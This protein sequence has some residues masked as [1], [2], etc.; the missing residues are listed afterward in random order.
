FRYF[1]SSGVAFVIDMSLLYAITEW[2]GVHYLVSNI[3][4]S[5]TAMVSN[6]LLSV[7]WVFSKRRVGNRAAEF[8]IF[9]LT[10]VA[11]LGLNQLL[12]WLFTD[13]VGLYYMISKFIAAVIGYLSKFF[14]RRSLLF[15]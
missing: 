6:Y 12:L 14:V 15:G 2:L 3:I 7:W 13:V 8:S 9:M 1:G 5:V 11:G 4:A 10:G